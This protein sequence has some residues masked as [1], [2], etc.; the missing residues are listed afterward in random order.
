[1]QMAATKKLHVTDPEKWLNNLR[2]ANDFVGIVIFRGS[3]CKYDKYY[4]QKLGDYS[5]GKM[6]DQ[7]LH[8]IAWTSE[9]EEG[10]QKADEQWS[11]TK[12]HGF[13]QVVGDETCAL[14][15]YLVEDGLLEKLT[16]SAFDDIRPSDTTDSPGRYP[17]GVVQPGMIWYAHHTVVLEWEATVEP[18]YFGATN[19][20][21]PREL[22][23]VVV[24]RKHELDRGDTVFMVHGN[25][26]KQC[27]TPMEVNCAIM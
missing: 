21:N 9:G 1:M 14:S 5:K 13:D 18:P 24:K 4:L 7:N 10:A 2:D 20:P 12:D 6:A 8:L 17:N 22:F 26:L 3:W 25:R 19:R 11:L 16:T 15:K 23:E 27:C